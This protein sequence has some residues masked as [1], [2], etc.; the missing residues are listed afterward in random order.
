MNLEERI[1]PGKGILNRSLL[2]GTFALNLFLFG[3]YNEG[4]VHEPQ[5]Q[6]RFSTNTQASEISEELQQKWPI[7]K[8]T[9]LEINKHKGPSV[10]YSYELNI[11]PKFYDGPMPLKFD[12]TQDLD[13]SHMT[14]PNMIVHEFK[15]FSNY[16]IYERREL[17][18]VVSVNS[19]NSMVAEAI[20]TYS[21]SSEDIW[22]KPEIEEF[23][24][25]NGLLVYHCLS[26]IDRDGFKTEERKSSGKKQKEYFFIL[27]FGLNSGMR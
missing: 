6:S 4:N 16:F 21:T 13:L 7:W 12:F 10:K 25:S 17:K 11:K 1:N 3:C 26:T 22:L 23:H 5:G 20:I 9:D 8:P 18:G 15:D 27:P 24:Y 14:T 19:N 2:T